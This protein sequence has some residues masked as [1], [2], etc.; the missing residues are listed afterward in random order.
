MI[1]IAVVGVSVSATCVKISRLDTPNAQRSIKGDSIKLSKKSITQKGRD[2]R[3]TIEA[4]TNHPSNQR[5]TRAQVHKKK[6]KTETHTQT[7][8]ADL[9]CPDMSAKKQ[10]ELDT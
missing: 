8:K 9:C 6:K 4:Y 7:H 3:K 2:T 5:T 10:R 1:V